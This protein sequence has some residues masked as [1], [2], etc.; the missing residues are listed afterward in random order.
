MFLCTD[1]PDERHWHDCTIPALL[2][3]V[4]EG[5]D[6]EV[7]YLKSLTAAG[8]D[9]ESEPA[10]T[11]PEKP[12]IFTNVDSYG[13]TITTRASES[14]TGSESTGTLGARILS[15]LEDGKGP[16]LFGFMNHHV[17]SKLELESRPK[18]EP[19]LPSDLMITSGSCW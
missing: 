3:L 14:R 7:R 9:S 6:I 13:T 10:P 11:E 5:I 12:D 1:D 16:V 8:N 18:D 15:D 19:L 17:L 4:G 2:V